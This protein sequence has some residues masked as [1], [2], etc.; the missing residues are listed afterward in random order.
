MDTMDPSNL[1][2]T[3]DIRLTGADKRDGRQL[4]TG[5]AQFIRGV[6]DMDQLPIPELPEVAFAG[7]SNVGKS[8]LL[9]A[10]TA[11]RDLARTSSTPGRTQQLNFF[12]LGKKMMLVDLPGYGY[13]KAPKTE[14]RKW[15]RLTRDYLKGRPNLRRVNLLIDSRHGIKDNDKS[16]MELLDEAAVPY[17]IIFT[18]SDKVKQHD[19]PDHIQ[20]AEDQL[21]KHA[22]AYPRILATSVVTDYNIDQLRASLGKLRKGKS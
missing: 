10:L 4:F 2:P 19:L 18:K 20:S 1:P 22:G 15:T 5:P 13:A 6:A 3:P 16:I 14:I 17:H 7:R 8:S 12:E 21:K 11:K 9:N